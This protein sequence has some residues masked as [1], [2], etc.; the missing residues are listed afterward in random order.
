MIYDCHNKTHAKVKVDFENWILM[1]QEV[2]P[3]KV[4]TGKSDEMK[5]IVI[6]I[7]EYYDFPYSIPLDNVGMINVM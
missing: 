4:I 2:T 6:E 3:H 5:K 7:L 1:Y